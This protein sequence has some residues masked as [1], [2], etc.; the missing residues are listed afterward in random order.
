MDTW[1]KEMINAAP[2]TLSR[3]QAARIARR[4]PR[5]IDRWREGGHLEFTEVPGGGGPGKHAVP[6]VM[7]FTDSLRA[8]LSGEHG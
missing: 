1:Q 5:T 4:T 7:I 2:E 8:Y 6:K 3:A